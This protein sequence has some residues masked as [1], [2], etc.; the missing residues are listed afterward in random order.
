[1]LMEAKRFLNGSLTRFHKSLLAEIHEREERRNQ[2][3]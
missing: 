3:E 1:M 2:I